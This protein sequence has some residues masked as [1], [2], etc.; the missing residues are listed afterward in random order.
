MGVS[1]SNKKPCKHKLANNNVKTNN[2]D[3]TVPL[4]YKI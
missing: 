2:D 4:R 3:Y 1:C